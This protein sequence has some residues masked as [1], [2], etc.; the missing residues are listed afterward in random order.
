[1]NLA[2]RHGD[3]R[4]LNKRGF[5][6]TSTMQQLFVRM[7]AKYLEWRK[8]KDMQEELEEAL[9]KSWFE[10]EPGHWVYAK[11]EE[12]G[13][14][15]ATEFQQA[16]PNFSA[17]EDTRHFTLIDTSKTCPHCTMRRK[18]PGRMLCGHCIS[19]GYER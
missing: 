7:R 12:A 3:W 15:F 18:E 6:P 2:A 17:P 8:R 1:V 14:A 11:N 10:I 9:P 5:E 13:R 16:A 4:T 19:N